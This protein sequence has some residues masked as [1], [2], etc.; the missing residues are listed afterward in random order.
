MPHASLRAVLIGGL[1]VAVPTAS[2]H[3]QDPSPSFETIVKPFLEEN[4]VSCHGNR[5]QKGGLNLQ[6]YKSIEEVT[7]D[8]DR[9]E[10]VIRKVRD[11]EMPP[12]EEEP[13]PDPDQIAAMTAF[14]EQEIAKAD[15]AH[16]IDPGR[17]TARRLNRTEYNN[18]VRDLL[19]V[20][21]DPAARFP[22]DDSGY[23]FDNIGDVLS[24]SPL[25]ME[26]Y[27]AAAEEISRLA[28]FGFERRKPA[29]VKLQT[30]T[31]RIRESTEP[32]T[33]YDVSGLSLPNAAH[34]SYRVPIS[35]EYVVRLLLSGRRP[36]GSDPTRFALWI[37][38]QQI[39]VQEVDAEGGASFEPDHQEFA[40]RRLEFR[41]HLT[42][43]EHW[44]AG[45]VLELYAGLPVTYGGPKPSSRPIPPKP[46]FKPRPNATP[47]QNEAARKR[48]EERYSQ[49]Q[50]ANAVRVSGIEIIGPYA[51]ET[52]PSRASLEKIYTCGHFDGRHR[53]W[54][55]TKIVAS[56]A[57]RA[58]R[59]PIRQTEIDR[60]LALAK[61][62]ERE[63]GSF[64]EGLAAAIQA[65]LVSPDFLF[66]I[67]RGSPVKVAAVSHGIPLTE[68][69]LATR[70]SYFLWASMPDE[71]LIAAADRRT[72]RTPEGLAA[73]VKRMLADP[74]AK[75]LAEHFAGQWLQVRA[76]ESATPDRER[77]P[78]F[79]HYLRLSMRR[80]TELFVDSIFR[81][82]RSILDLLD[83]RYTFLNE[84]LARHY[85]IEGVEGPE[86]RRV[87][88]KDPVRG[89]ILTH[90]SV[91][92]VSSYATRTSPVLRG[93][94][95]LD[96][97]LNA[98]PPEPPPDVPN[99]DDKAVGTAASLRQQLEQ[100]RAD[101]SCSPCHK[102][103]DPLGF[104]LENFD[105]IGA[106]RTH[107]GT[108]PI[109]ASGTLPDGRSFKGPAELRAIL[110]SEREAFTRAVTSK[111]MTYALGRGLERYDRRAVREIAAAVAKDDYRFSSLVL[112]IVSSP[113]FQMRRA[114]RPSP[115][116]PARLD[117][118][119]A[120]TDGG[121]PPR[122]LAR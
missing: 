47:E 81:G 59:R 21:T 85:G 3:A 12:E 75:T 24:L 101:P 108:I 122:E 83:A 119:T 9:W 52:A 99:L 61:T 51:H 90:A 77:F 36:V 45:T 15:E 50:P 95:I 71:E 29:L 67:E 20:D 14:V 86:F 26:K 93:K 76:L 106:W 91:L 4:C 60:L 111:L 13:R 43:G 1:L 80:E 32:L 88:L 17:V 120:R 30:L 49:K 100:H 40:G 22:H 44:F 31:G 19:G 58:F 117:S 96:N 35:G 39:G 7:R 42:A 54:C 103:M 113:A 6:A 89:G 115:P 10:E 37:D 48:F 73:Q 114:E 110:A 53:A 5:R 109:D 63:T 98:P 2:A 41:T 56:L 104:G 38:G 72:L 82:D 121:K 118:Q 92:T 64:E 16:G 57:R 62:A 87:T 66:R 33:A 68:H 8:A 112:H 74:R 94:W 46:E 78:D 28:L 79:D 97:I 105:A 34:A 27:M 65:I 107:D 116:E 84:R 11:G 23:G 102:R 69:E 70:L 18:T 25:L 55:R